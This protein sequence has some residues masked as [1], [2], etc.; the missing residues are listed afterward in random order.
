M[1][2]ILMVTHGSGGDI[3]PFV[4]LAAGLI[5]RG[6]EP[7][8]LTHQPYESYARR[9][10]A[11]FVP[12]DNTADYAEYMVRS[13]DLLRLRSPA[14]LRLYY[15]QNGLF[16]QLRLECDTLAAWHRPGDT[17]L[18]GRYSTGLSVLVAAEVLDAAAAWVA[19]SPTQ[20]ITSRVSEFY[21][22]TG[23]GPEIDRVRAAYGLG[24]VTDFRSWLRSARLTLGLWPEWFDA[25]GTAAPPG[26]QVAGFVAGD[27]LGIDDSG[28]ELPEP[29]AALLGGPESPVLATGG[30]GRALHEQF[31]PVA[32]AAAARLGRPT[33]VV[34]PYP[35][36][37]PEPL[38][39]TMTWV[40]RVSFLRVL[41]HCAAIVHHGG[42]GTAM[43]ALRAGVPQVIMAHGMDRPDNAA[44]LA[45][46]EL[47]Q[48]TQSQDW[49]VS[50]VCAQLRDA[51]ADTGYRVR[52]RTIL[53]DDD[54]GTAVTTAVEALESLRKCS[55]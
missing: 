5:E 55:G 47:A 42:I 43:R 13:T 28:G 39:P 10:G 29:V 33:L 25:A 23:L 16:D 53:M 34:T 21:I 46:L 14:D 31:Y 35:E 2:R 44:R 48:W 4:R 8:L 49:T 9:I 36:L 40:P 41:P 22:T 52:A 17:V 24:P 6:H 1:S 51:V 12:I 15:E 11:E 30:T 54:A 38:P 27:E 20:L 26:V 3:I 18:V 7:V 19:V 45:K 37:L 50:G 32:V